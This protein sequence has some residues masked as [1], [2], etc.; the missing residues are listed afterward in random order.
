VCEIS[1]NS[2]VLK[3]TTEGAE[4]D[5][6]PGAHLD[7]ARERVLEDSRVIVVKEACGVSEM[8]V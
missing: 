4:V 2:S 3:H 1:C 5:V 7:F 8:V 6:D